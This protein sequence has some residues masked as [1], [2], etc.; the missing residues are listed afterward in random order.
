MT[1]SAH[2][3]ATI[4]LPASDATPVTSGS[5]DMA[6][7]LRKVSQSWANNRKISNFVPVLL[8]FDMRHKHCSATRYEH[9]ARKVLHE[10]LKR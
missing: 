1:A 3:A 7:G 6:L 4:S 10:R 9:A 8:Q 2:L 5:F